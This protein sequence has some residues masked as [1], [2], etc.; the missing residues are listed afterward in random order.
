MYDDV[1]A[2]Y[3]A[4]DPKYHGDEFGFV[5]V[6]KDGAWFSGVRPVGAVIE[7]VLNGAMA[8]LAS[9][10]LHS[11]VSP[12]SMPQGMS[13]GLHV[14]ETLQ[15][16]VAGELATTI[17]AEAA[18]A[19]NTRQKFSEDVAEALAESAINKAANKH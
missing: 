6:S 19:S 16:A 7:S 17:G 2:L 4:R 14:G 18:H 9:L 11:V 13:F 15:A 1:D 12:L 10:G 3:I 8:K 5:A